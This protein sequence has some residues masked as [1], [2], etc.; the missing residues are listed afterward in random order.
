MPEAI[1]EVTFFFNQ[2][3]MGKAVT[4]VTN[5][6]HVKFVPIYGIHHL[7]STYTVP[8]HAGELL[9]HFSDVLFC[10]WQAI[11]LIARHNSGLVLW[12]KRAVLRVCWS[13]NCTKSPIHNQ[14]YHAYY[15]DLVYSKGC[16]HRYV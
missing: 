16:T 11:Y 12:V 15:K 1:D 9:H 8:M 5:F 6:F 10:T 7:F 3:A 4:R 13:L 2:A 14:H